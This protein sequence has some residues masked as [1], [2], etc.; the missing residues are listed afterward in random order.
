MTLGML[1]RLTVIVWT[2]TAWGAGASSLEEHAVSMRQAARPAR[3]GF[4]GGTPSYLVS[5]CAGAKV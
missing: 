2:G 1:W 5:F 3:I 4:M